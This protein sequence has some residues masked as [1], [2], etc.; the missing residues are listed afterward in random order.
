[1]FSNSLFVKFENSQ[2]NEASSLGFKP[3]F[4]YP[5]LDIDVVDDS[6]TRFLLANQA[7][8]FHWVDMTIVRRAIKNHEPDS[9]PNTPRFANSRR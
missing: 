9:R 4:P 5:V 1:M 2:A 8:I 6:H 7:G 3:D